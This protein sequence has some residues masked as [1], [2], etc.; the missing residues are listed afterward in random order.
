[1]LFTF[2]CFTTIGHCFQPPTDDEGVSAW[3]PPDR[4]IISPKFII[5][6]AGF[7]TLFDMFTSVYI[8]RRVLSPPICF[9]PCGFFF[10]SSEDSVANVVDLL[11]SPMRTQTLLATFSVAT[12][13]FASSISTQLLRDRALDP[14]ISGHL[15]GSWTYIGCYGD[16]VIHRALSN[17]YTDNELM[18]GEDCI[19]FCDSQ[20]YPVAG[21]GMLEFLSFRDSTR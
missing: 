18:T 3:R 8:C 15:P 11:S 1:M 16:H 6:T 19:S 17:S 12:S 10:T 20:G 4:S 21:T 2:T 13:T 5:A 14:A 7:L 9:T